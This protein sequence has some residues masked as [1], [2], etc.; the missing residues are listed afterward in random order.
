MTSFKSFNFDTC[1]I[2]PLNGLEKSDVSIRVSKI[3]P[4]G[5]AAADGRLLAG[6]RI[7]KANGVDFSRVLHADALKTIKVKCN[8][9]DKIF[10]L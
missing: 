5:A 9:C 3:I 6:D 4:N 8:P 7:V 2:R 10:L 1:Y